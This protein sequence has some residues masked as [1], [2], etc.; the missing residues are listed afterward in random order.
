VGL[1]LIAVTI[2]NITVN[3]AP[4]FKEG[5]IQRMEKLREWLAKRR[6]IRAKIIEEN[7]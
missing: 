1:S 6:E 4:V 2:F 5:F 7:I 3:L